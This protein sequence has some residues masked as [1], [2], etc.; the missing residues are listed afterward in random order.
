MRAT[1]ESISTSGQSASSTCSRCI[2]CPGASASTL[3]RRDPCRRYHASA[4]TV[5]PSTSTSNPPS[6]RISTR[7]PP[8]LEDHRDELYDGH[9][10]RDSKD[11][12]WRADPRRSSSGPERAHDD[13]G[14]VVLAPAHDHAV[15]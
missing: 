4:G 9:A 6:K 1:A 15:G 5:R 2:R 14:V 13:A 3:T 10:D 12:R 11:V 7:T 8:T